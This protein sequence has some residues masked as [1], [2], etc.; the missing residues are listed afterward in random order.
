L[1]NRLKKIEQ[2]GPRKMSGFPWKTAN[3]ILIVAISSIVA[4][5]VH[6]NNGFESKLI[7]N[8]PIM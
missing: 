2:E 4:F 7:H 1:I 5:D 6:K 8:A 3:L